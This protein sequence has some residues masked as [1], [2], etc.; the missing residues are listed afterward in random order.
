VASREKI[1][2]GKVLPENVLQ[3]HSPVYHAI[4]CMN[5][6]QRGFSTES[7]NAKSRKP[8]NILSPIDSIQRIVGL[9]LCVP[10][11]VI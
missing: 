10:F 8:A 11:F 4:S 7:G 1:E 6:M 5:Q 9:M 3:L 2:G